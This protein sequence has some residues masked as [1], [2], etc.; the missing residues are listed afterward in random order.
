MV[1]R[2]VC[3]SE[4]CG[5]YNCVPNACNQL[6]NSG[7]CQGNWGRHSLLRT[8]LGAHRESEK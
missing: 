8:K 1:L 4:E 3:P 5:E 7:D 2:I 6:K